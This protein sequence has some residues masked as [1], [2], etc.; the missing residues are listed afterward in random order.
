MKDWKLICLRKKKKGGGGRKG[1]SEYCKISI[2][3][4]VD[5]EE[6]VEADVDVHYNNREIQR[7]TIFV[8]RKETK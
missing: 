7:R 8:G 4:L 3:S 2:V 1:V 5:R 6:E